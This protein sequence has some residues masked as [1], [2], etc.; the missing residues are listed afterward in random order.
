MEF[1][2]LVVHIHISVDCHNLHSV[3]WTLQA[4]YECTELYADWRNAIS[5]LIHVQIYTILIQDTRYTR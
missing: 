5:F 1:S 3:Q 2:Y 4:K